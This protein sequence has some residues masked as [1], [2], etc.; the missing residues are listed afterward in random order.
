MMDSLMQGADRNLVKIWQKMNVKR[1]DNTI[2]KTKTVGGHASP[3]GIELT[4]APAKEGGNAP[5]SAPI[6]Y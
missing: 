4:F 1:F 2:H 6:E 3:E 5:V